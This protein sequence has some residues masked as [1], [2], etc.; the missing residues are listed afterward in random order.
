[1]AMEVQLVFIRLPSVAFGQLKVEPQAAVGP[2]LIAAPQRILGLVVAPGGTLEEA[3]LL[4][5]G[6]HTQ[7]H[8]GHAVAVAEDIASAARNQR[9]HPGGIPSPQRLAHQRATHIG[10]AAVVAHETRVGIG[11]HMERQR[12]ASVA[13]GPHGLQQPHQLEPSGVARATADGGER[14]GGVAT[15]AGTVIEATVVVDGQRRVATLK[16]ADET[17]IAVLPEPAAR[18]LVDALVVGR[19]G[20]GVLLRLQRGCNQHQQYPKNIAFHILIPNS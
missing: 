9:L 16:A 18:L 19:H 11:S 17:P 20:R 10:V 12:V 15:L 3:P 6:Q 2:A 13:G 8:H 14:I 1:M 7:L 5:R 4:R